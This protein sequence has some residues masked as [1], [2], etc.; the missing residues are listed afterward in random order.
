MPTE[1]R[2]LWF[3]GRQVIAFLGPARVQPGVSAEP[4]L[5]CDWVFKKGDCNMNRREIIGV[6]G[7]GL[8]GM[9]LRPS[10]A[11]AQHPHHHDE[12]HGECLKACEACATICNET[13]HHSFHKLKDG[14]AEHHRTAIVTID[15]QEFCRLSAELMSRE[16][17]L[18]S[19][20][21]LASA[22]ACNLCAVECSRH[23]D[24]QMRECADACKNCE[25]A[26]RAMVK[27]IATAPPDAAE[28]GSH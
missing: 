14:H 22:D 24:P 6:V 5:L 11:R 10:E 13:F 28:K 19:I 9:A 8:A 7:V 16:S 21:C 27:A 25:R 15:C 26:C 17:P 18:I 2:K 1:L 4:C 12:L 20:A 3:H 23:D